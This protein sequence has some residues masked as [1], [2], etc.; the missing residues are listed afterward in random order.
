MNPHLSL[1]NFANDATC[2]HSCAKKAIAARNRDHT[3]RLARGKL[4]VLTC[5]LHVQKGQLWC[6]T[7][8]SPPN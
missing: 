8:A 1:C 7:K 2:D 4:H 3:D 5:N 6:S